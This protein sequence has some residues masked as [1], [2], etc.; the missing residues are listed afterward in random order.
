MKSVY[1]LQDKID[2]LEHVDEFYIQLLTP[3]TDLSSFITESDVFTCWLRENAKISDDLKITKT[4]LIYRKDDGK[5]VCGYFSLMFSSI[6]YDKDMKLQNM[7]NC[8]EESGSLS[9][10][11]LA[12]SVDFAEKYCHIVKF[13]IN[14][15]KTIAL[16]VSEYVNVRYITVDADMD[17]G[18]EDIVKIYENAGFKKLITKTVPEAVSMFLD[19]YHKD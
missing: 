10:Y 5:N 7:P 1:V 12:T 3:D 16:H 4:Y 18:N 8:I 9:I 19:I 14:C 2:L 13:I 17:N 11:Y 15:V 6:K